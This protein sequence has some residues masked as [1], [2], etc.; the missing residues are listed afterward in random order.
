MTE[1]I[2]N[3]DVGGSALREKSRVTG[4]KIRATP[5]PSRLRDLADHLL[6]ESDMRRS[7]IDAERENWNGRFDDLKRVDARA[8]S[9]LLGVLEDAD[10][11]W[12]YGEGA[13]VAAVEWIATGRE[14]KV[15]DVV[16]SAKVTLTEERRSDA[17]TTAK[18]RQEK[19]DDHFYEDLS[20]KSESPRRAYLGSGRRLLAHAGDKDYGIM[21]L[22]VQLRYQ[23]DG[24][25]KIPP[26]CFFPEPDVDSACVK[27]IRK[28]EPPLSWE[29]RGL[30]SRIVKR[31]FSQRRKM[32]F[33]LLKEQWPVSVLEGVFAQAG[34]STQVRAEAVSL[35]QFVALTEALAAILPLGSEV[36]GQELKP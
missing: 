23:M 5:R 28:V 1:K 11:S 8:A 32:M 6:R 2:V 10:T 21:T 24:W 34:L 18:C 27:L 14:P 13:R 33:K 20:L 9:R 15:E 12:Q 3:V 16:E 36:L 29:T 26:S 30:Y 7:S 25:F 17:N 19:T 22:L 4:P 31:G 35:E